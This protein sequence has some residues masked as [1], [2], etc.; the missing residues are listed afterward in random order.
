VSARHAARFGWGTEMLSRPSLVGTTSGWPILCLSSSCG[1][2]SGTAGR[3]SGADSSI[4][5]A[6]SRT[7]TF[8]R[9][10]D[11]LLDQYPGVRGCSSGES[12]PKIWASRNMVTV[13]CALAS[14]GSPGHHIGYH[15]GARR[16]PRNCSTAASSPSAGRPR[17][18]RG[19]SVLLVLPGR[20]G[21]AVG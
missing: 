5:L 2:S 17:E 13:M 19:P 14:V 9:P 21:A 1:I 12:G 3:S 18:A 6:R 4:P 8:R 7:S 10:H 15:R 11:H 20:Q 16:V